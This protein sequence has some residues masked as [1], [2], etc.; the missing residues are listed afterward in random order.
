[1]SLEAHRPTVHEE[2]LGDEKVLVLENE[3]LRVVVS[4]DHGAGIL[5]LVHRP[6]GVPLLWK[7]P[8]GL[9]APGR[10]LLA[11]CDASTTFFDYYPGGCQVVLPNG[12][13]SVRHNGVELGFHGE[14]CKVAWNWSTVANSEMAAVACETSLRRAP[15]D[16]SISYELAESASSLTIAMTVR[17]VSD[18]PVDCMW[19]LHPAYSEPFLGNRTRLHIGA[20]DVEGHPEQFANRQ[21][22][23]PGFQS[24]WPIGPDGLRLDYLFNGDGATADLMYLKQTDGWYVL[25]NEESGLAA[26]MKWD[27]DLFPFVWLWQECR[28]KAGYP[29]FGR[30]HIVGVEPF[31]SYPSMGIAEALQRGNALQL[32]PRGAISTVLRIGAVQFPVRQ[33]TVAGVNDD[34]SVTFEEGEERV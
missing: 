24:R 14:A 12:G 2:L 22:L 32:P 6:T 16:V 3:E 26:T 20:K 33:Q 28:D 10:D 25:H 30:Y 4:P 29:W 1:V 7:A 9:R 23:L 15:L 31:T 11:E 18:A 13:P 21:N 17:N 34:G 19:G 5:D 8:G 27:S